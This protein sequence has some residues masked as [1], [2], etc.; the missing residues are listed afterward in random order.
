MRL[1]A[2]I[3]KTGIAIILAMSIAS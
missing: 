2:R 3:F 1:G